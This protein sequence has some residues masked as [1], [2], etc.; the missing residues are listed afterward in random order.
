M[1]ATAGTKQCFGGIDYS[2]DDIYDHDDIRINIIN[3]I[4][5]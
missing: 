3:I 2:S 4:K 5:P 1:L